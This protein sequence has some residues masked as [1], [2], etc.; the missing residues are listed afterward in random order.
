MFDLFFFKSSDIYHA[1]LDFP[2]GGLHL[3]LTSKIDKIIVHMIDGYSEIGFI[4]APHVLSYHLIPWTQPFNPYPN[5]F[6]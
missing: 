3:A 2:G 1:R 4:R 5:V 6:A